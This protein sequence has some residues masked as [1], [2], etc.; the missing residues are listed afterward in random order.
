MK[1]LSIAILAIILTF[2]ISTLF[3]SCGDN[4]DDANDAAKE[5]VAENEDTTED[6][7]EDTT[8]AA[9]YSAG[10]TIYTNK[11]M[12]CHQENGEGVD[13]SFPALKG[14]TADLDIVV[15]GTDGTAMAAFKDQLS[16]QEIVDVINYVNHAW[17]NNA[18]AI[19]LDD[20][21]SAKK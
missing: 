7:A 18:D 20:I 17:G 13:P 5:M 4:E 1:K 9:D 21:T 12:A 11:C 16:D 2:S 8:E 14:K 10:K 3:T 6:V 19:T 15:N